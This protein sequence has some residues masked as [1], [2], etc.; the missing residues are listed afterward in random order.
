LAAEVGGGADDRGIAVTPVVSVARENTRLTAL[1][2]H[3]AAVVIV[4]DFGIQCFP[5][6]GCST[7]E[8]SCG[9]MNLSRAATRNI[10][11]FAYRRSP[12]GGCQ[13]FFRIFPKKRD[14]DGRETITTAYL[15]P[16]ANYST[17][18]PNEKPRPLG[19]TGASELAL[20]DRPAWGW[21]WESPI[22]LSFQ[23]ALKPI[24]PL[25]AA[26]SPTASGQGRGCRDNNQSQRAKAGR[27]FTLR[28]PAL[29]S[30]FRGCGHPER[31][32]EFSGGLLVSAASPANR[33]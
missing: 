8:A 3:L 10:R 20:M 4:F 23:R 19:G 6:G 30:R 28:P 5:S 13:G 24:V 17:H 1:N 32:L 9:S 27:L 33:I 7:G 2:Q 18:M 31:D 12:D 21:G 29:E 11:G 15:P 22:R 16:E 25:A 26:S 14:G